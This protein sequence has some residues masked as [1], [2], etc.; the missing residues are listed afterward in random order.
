MKICN[1]KAVGN[2]IDGVTGGYL[3]YQGEFAEVANVGETTG[4]PT[5]K[6]LVAL[7]GWRNRYAVIRISLGLG[8]NR[9]GVEIQ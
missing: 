5:Q 4:V 2:L 9:L 7:S 8:H 3:R 6:R 1:A